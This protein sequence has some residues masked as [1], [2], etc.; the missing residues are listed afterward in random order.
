M[1]M[2][3]AAFPAS[4]APC[5]GA[6][7]VATFLTAAKAFVGSLPIDLSVNRERRF[8]HSMCAF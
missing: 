4:R 7:V 1:L 8:V 6:A 5:K 3:S 2:W